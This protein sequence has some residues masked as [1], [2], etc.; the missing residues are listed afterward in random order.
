M[1]R[2]EILKT[3]KIKEAK[4]NVVTSL[5]RSVQQRFDTFAKTNLQFKSIAVCEKDK[6]YIV[7]DGNKNFKSLKS[8]GV[9]KV[10]CYN[11]GELPDG[12]YEVIR[13]LLNIHQKRLDYIGIATKIKTAA[14]TIRPESIATKTGLDLDTVEKYLDLLNFNWESFLKEEINPQINPFNDEK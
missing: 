13:I 9:K 1:G 3:K 6:G 10:L 11:F 2:F 5:D 8:A 7:V 14:K 4:I 12:E